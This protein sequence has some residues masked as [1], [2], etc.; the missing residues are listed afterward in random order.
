MSL[1]DL[2]RAQAKAERILKK[3]GYHEQT[4]PC[5]QNCKNA[6]FPPEE[7]IHCRLLS[8]SEWVVDEVSPLAICKK[9][10]AKPKEATP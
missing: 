8:V 3:N 1:N 6:Y 2:Y 7:G 4:F 5:C 10:E 9:H